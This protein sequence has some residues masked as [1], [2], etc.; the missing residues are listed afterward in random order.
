L[1]LSYEGRNYAESINFEFGSN[2]TELISI[3]AE[4]NSFKII[5]YKN[6]YAEE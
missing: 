4:R 1:H 2:A 6:E 5:I 3:T